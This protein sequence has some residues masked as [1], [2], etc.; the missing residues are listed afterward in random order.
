MTPFKVFY[1]LCDPLIELVCLLKGCWPP[2]WVCS[3]LCTQTHTYLT[4]T[5]P[6]TDLP[7]GACP[8]KHTGSL[9]HSVAETLWPHPSCR[10]GRGRDA[11][12]CQST[13]C[14]HTLCSGAQSSSAW[15]GPARE[16]RADWDQFDIN[17]IQFRKLF[18]FPNPKFDVTDL[19]RSTQFTL[20]L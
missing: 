19:H 2:P 16:K 1:R 14:S 18:Q 6:H 4:I 12:L 5:D 10:S 7:R 13:P 8:C 11:P 3:Y 15:G 20:S 9:L 17:L